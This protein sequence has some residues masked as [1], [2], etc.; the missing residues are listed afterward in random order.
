ML[1]AIAHIFSRGLFGPVFQ[2]EV[3]VT[4]RRVS[5]YWIRPLY[6]LGLAVIAS[7]VYLAVTADTRF[8]NSG[9]AEALQNLQIFAP[10]LGAVFVWFQ[11]VLSSFISAT[12]TA[13]AI[14]DE[15]RK[16][17]LASLI[18]TPLTA[19]EIILG[20]LSGRLTQL[21]ILLLTGLPLLLAVRIFG[22][23]SAHFIIAAFTI[24]LSVS[25]LHAAIA[26]AAS[27]RARSATTAASSGLLVGIVWC[28]APM[29]VSG[30]LAASRV[31]WAEVP[32]IISPYFAL[33]LETARSLGE[34]GPPSL[35]FQTWAYGALYPLSGAALFTALAV[36]RF[37]DLARRAGEGSLPATTREPKPARKS[38]ASAAHANPKMSGPDPIVVR[39]NPVL[40][41]ELRQPLYAQRWYPWAGVIGTFA[42]L[43]FVR[44]QVGS[45]DPQ[46]LIIFAFIL[47]ALFFF[48]ASII[49]AGAIAGERETRSLEVLLATPLTAAAV[50]LAKW[51]GSMRRLLPIPS[52]FALVVL[53]AGVLPGV[54]SPVLYA[55]LVLL[56]VPPAA[57]LAAT[58]LWLSVVTRRTVVA[59]TINLIGAVGAWAAAPAL[60]GAFGAIFRL[61]PDSGVFGILVDVGFILNPAAMTFNA[62]QGASVMKNAAFGTGYR[63]I[64]NFDLLTFTLASA[65]SALVYLILT[66][67]TLR[68]AA[69]SLARRT[70]RIR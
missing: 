67:I 4:G 11:F 10:T 14:C 69:R 17:S 27:S 21:A 70:N 63:S 20:K 3:R 61:N 18:A 55:H 52:L 38:A 47:S 5:T 40:W 41:R 33:G 43:G 64:M 53:V 54:F 12:L 62:I 6:V 23:I 13:G 45:F 65:A 44:W 34:T 66:W 2:R 37:R 42:I 51:V 31:P 60:V 68:L 19:I 48:Q 25:L 50:V 46:I 59:S 29:I 30:L 9:N 26:I 56:L 39:G 1:A 8:S 36:W 58:G 35:M 49:S 22:G 57:L 32:L 7:I 16:G 15:R 24:T 28:L